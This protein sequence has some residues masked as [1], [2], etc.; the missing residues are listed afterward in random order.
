MNVA[1][2]HWRVRWLPDTLVQA[3]LLS[4]WLYCGTQC[5]YVLHFLGKNK[6]LNMYIK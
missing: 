2:A 6:K 1:S 3:S 5:K 4:L